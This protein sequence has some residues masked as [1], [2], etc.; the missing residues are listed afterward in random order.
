MIND[1]NELFPYSLFR[2]REFKQNFIF[3]GRNSRQKARNKSATFLTYI[4]K[5]EML[6]NKN[7]SKIKQKRDNI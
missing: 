1:K 2:G 3:R 7:E 5:D 4:D 6:C